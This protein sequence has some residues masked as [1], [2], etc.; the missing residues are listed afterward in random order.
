MLRGI[1]SA[2][3]ASR[4]GMSLGVSDRYSAHA[5]RRK[6]ALMLGPRVG[7][8]GRD[9]TSKRSADGQIGSG[10]TP[11]LSDQLQLPRTTDRLVTVGRG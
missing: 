5:Q 8:L 2:R 9:L 1:G 7:A 10:D 3:T 6:R 11:D 4:V